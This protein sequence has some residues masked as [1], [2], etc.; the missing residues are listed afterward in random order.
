MVFI[1]WLIYLPDLAMNVFYD[2]QF[3]NIFRLHF[4]LSHTV[5]VRCSFIFRFGVLK[6]HLGKMKK[7]FFV[8][9]WHILMHNSCNCSIWIK[10][11]NWAYMLG[12]LVIGGGRVHL[13]L[14]LCLCHLTFNFVTAKV[15]RKFVK[16][17]Y[18]ASF[19]V[20]TLDDV[21]C[22]VYYAGESSVKDKTEADGNITKHSHDDKRRQCL[23]DKRFA[24][25]RAS[26]VRSGEKRF[27]C[28]VCDKQFGNRS[29]WNDHVLTHSGENLYSCSHCEKRFP[30]PSYLRSHMNLHTD[31][32][33]CTEC[34]KRCG[35]KQWLTKHSRVHSGE[36]PFE[37]NVCKK[38]F[39]S[40][41]A[42]VGHSRIH[43]GE[44]PYKC[45]TCDKSFRHCGTLKNHIR[46]HTGEKPYRCNQCDKAFRV[47]GQLIVHMRGHTGDKPYKCS[48]C[49]KSF[50][51]S[52]HLE[53]HKLHIHTNRRPHHCPFCGKMFKTKRDLTWHV[54]IHAA[55][56][57]YSCRH[58]SRRFTRS[59]QLKRHLLKSHNE[60]TWHVCNICLKKSVTSGDLKDHLRR[61]G[62]VKP[63]VCSECS[64][65]FFTADEWKRHLQVHS[66]V[67]G[68]GCIL[69][70]KSFRHRKSVLM[71]FKTCASELGSSDIFAF[72]SKKWH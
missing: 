55:T 7:C 6:E 1:G 63:Y 42:L 64:K 56:K 18:I 51:E 13:H 66:D 14:W 29:Q 68:F 69:C 28:T 60:G 53:N 47:H 27:V 2:F 62:G 26:N 35:T 38:Q 59:D 31:K 70:N 15:L 19:L 30:N 61:H 58:C 3:H 41:K 25:K 32:Y 11:A 39:S 4:T 17:S 67:K 50:R 57:L 46:V 5:Y 36:K 34:G 12:V 10:P 54:H 37:C 33:K 72:T 9:K 22:Y 16:K 8:S 21:S 44:K 65:R 40:A 48:L 49:N 43:T 52:G 45:H 71:H 23:T 24:Q 20:L